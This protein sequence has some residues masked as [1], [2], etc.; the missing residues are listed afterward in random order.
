[1]EY[2]KALD[3]IILTK[4]RHKI[5][6]LPYLNKNAL[7]LRKDGSLVPNSRNGGRRG[8]RVK[9]TA[10]KITASIYDVPILNSERQ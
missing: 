4:H 9:E 8:Q 2:S 7:S 5:K 6:G 1:M 10:L 3:A